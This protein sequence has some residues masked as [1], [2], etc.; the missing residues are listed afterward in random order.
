MKF[1]ISLYT[2]IANQAKG[3]I[4]LKI[5]MML[6]LCLV[7]FPSLPVLAGTDQSMVTEKADDQTDT[8]HT[9]IH[10]LHANADSKDDIIACTEPRPQVCTQDYRPVCAEL[11][12]G[13]FKSFSTGCSACSDPAVTGY[14]GGACE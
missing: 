10:Q 5:A 11:Q 7:L 3:V 12:D 14:R 13:S 8:G 1:Y 6:G 4:M 2:S 9:F